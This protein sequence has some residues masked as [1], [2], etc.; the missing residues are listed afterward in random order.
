MPRV[1]RIE[2][3][4]DIRTHT[5]ISNIKKR[6]VCAYARVSTNSDEQET[7]YEAQVDYYRKYIRSITTGNIYK[8]ITNGSMSASTPTKV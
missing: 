2:P 5:S 3:T 1:I 8:H 6:R 7:S 4:V